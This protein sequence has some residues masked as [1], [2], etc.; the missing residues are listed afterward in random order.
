MPSMEL[1]VAEGLSSVEAT[2]LLGNF[3]WRLGGERGWKA[4]VDTGGGSV[5]VITLC[6]FER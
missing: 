4:Q 2:L 3:A 6:G 5:E 1:G